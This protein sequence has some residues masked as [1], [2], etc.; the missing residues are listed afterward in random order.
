[1]FLDG[2]E[3]GKIVVYSSKIKQANVMQRG[4]RI[5]INVG[6]MMGNSS[7]VGNVVTLT[8]FDGNDLDVC[9]AVYV[10]VNKLVY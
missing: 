10:E 3:H 5:F 4:D 2:R 1:M 9:D 8:Y 7:R 6:C